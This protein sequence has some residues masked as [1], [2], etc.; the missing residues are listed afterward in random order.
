MTVLKRLVLLTAIFLL[1]ISSAWADFR[2]GVEAYR[3]G[4]YRTAFQEWKLLAANGH[5]KAQSNLGLLYLR[6]QGVVKNEEFALEW[7]EKAAGQ[8]LVTAQFNLGILYSRIKGSLRSQTKSTKWYLS[9]AE[10]EH[11]TARYHL[12]KRYERGLGAERDAVEALRWSILAAESATGNLKRKVVAYR[13]RLRERMP[14][15][16][17]D[18]ATQLAAHTKGR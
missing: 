14:R 1:P 4:D 17:I 12:A 10:A 9:A 6:G 16:K 2:D 8:G 3:N 13:D 18:K 5:S 11:A 15:E 7:F